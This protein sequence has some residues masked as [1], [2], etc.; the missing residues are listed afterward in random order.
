MLQS[1]SNSLEIIKKGGGKVSLA[2]AAAKEV[3]QGPTLQIPLIWEGSLDHT[4]PKY[5]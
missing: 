3:A 1:S 4:R 5:S 2:E